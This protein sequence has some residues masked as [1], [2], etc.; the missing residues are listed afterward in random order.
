MKKTT[1]VLAFIIAFIL[2]S[3]NFI[4]EKR[5]EHLSTDTSTVV[6]ITKS[7]SDL[8]PIQ[9]DPLCKIV[10]ILVHMDKTY[11]LI[12]I[13]CAIAIYIFAWFLSM[14]D[15]C[16]IVYTWWDMVLLLICGGIVWFYFF[17]SSESINNQILVI[18][19]TASLIIS[20]ILSF[21]ANIKNPFPLNIVFSVVSIITKI[22]LIVFVP[23]IAF[24]I[25]N[26]FTSGKNDKRYKDGTKNNEK[27]AIVSFIFLLF[28][29]IVSPL[30]KTNRKSYLSDLI[31]NF[32]DE[33]YT[34]RFIYKWNRIIYRNQYK[35]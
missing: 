3:Y 17:D 28:G 22:I 5:Q 33:K 30:V 34:K 21:V 27:T 32:S 29:I 19:F 26:S 18:I 9:K 12:L 25:L 1:A 31:E 13:V 8:N 23:M 14:G 24:M 20:T 10:S 2:F 7:N 35:R 15:K 4:N 16:T 11:S 6:E